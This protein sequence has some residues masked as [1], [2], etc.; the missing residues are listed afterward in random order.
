[1]NTM[2][3]KPMIMLL[4]I[5]SLLAASPMTAQAAAMDNSLEALQKRFKSR[6]GALHK[7]KDNGTV[8]ETYKGYVDF[9][10]DHSDDDAASL[11]KEENA[12]REELYKLIAKKEKTTPEK[13]AERNAQRNFEKARPGQYLQDADGT[14]RKKSTDTSGKKDKS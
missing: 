7:L 1:M 9:V 14:W 12:D 2:K 8:G 3:T 4:M 10:K 11:V 6:Y 5:V 13:V